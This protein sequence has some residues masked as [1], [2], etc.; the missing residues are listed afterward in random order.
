M[1]LGWGRWEEGRYEVWKV[2]FAP[3]FLPR[4]TVTGIVFGKFSSHG[5][6]LLAL[7]K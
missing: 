3:F 2:H 7:A 1:L 6:N 5:A 4:E